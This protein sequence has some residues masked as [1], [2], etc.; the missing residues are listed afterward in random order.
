MEWGRSR[1]RWIPCRNSWH[2]WEQALSEFETGRYT[3]LHFRRSQRRWF[4]ICRFIT[5][6]DSR[7]AK[8]I[9]VRQKSSLMLSF[10]Q[11]IWCSVST[12]GVHD[13]TIPKQNCRDRRNV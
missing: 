3:L 8:N 2:I 5:C 7:A 10:H 13:Q 6:T 11:D 12:Y 9:F 4:I 1:D